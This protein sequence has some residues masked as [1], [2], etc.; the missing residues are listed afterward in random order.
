MNCATCIHVPQTDRETETDRQTDDYSLET[1]Y[2]LAI[3]LTFLLYSTPIEAL[4]ERLV[5]FGMIYYKSYVHLCCSTLG[6]S[7]YTTLAVVL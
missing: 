3:G 1:H 5:L 2:I 6:S 4:C 7:S